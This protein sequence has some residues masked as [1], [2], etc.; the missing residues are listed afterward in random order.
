MSKIHSNNPECMKL[1]QNKYYAGCK[2][3]SQYTKKEEDIAYYKLAN[4]LS[5]ESIRSY[6]ENSELDIGLLSYYLCETQGRNFVKFA[7]NI[8]KVDFIQ[9]HNRLSKLKKLQEKLNH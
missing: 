6:I 2:K 3:S 9:I 1:F 7:T 4:E 5:R 8:S